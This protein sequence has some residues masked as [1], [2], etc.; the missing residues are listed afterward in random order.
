MTGQSEPKM[1]I[2]VAT[3]SDILTLAEIHFQALPNDLLPRIGKKFL[4]EY[5]YPQLLQSKHAL[6]LVYTQGGATKSFVVF[7][8]DSD[9]LTQYILSQ[10]TKM[11]L[12]LIPATF[13]SYKLIFDV[14][15]H[16]RGSELKLNGKSDLEIGKIPE[17]Y[18]MATNS[19][20]T[21]SGV[22]GRLITEGL[23]IMAN[24]SPSCMV[25]TSS[26]RAK[27]FYMKY[28]FKEIGFERRGNRILNLLLR[29]QKTK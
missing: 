1:A 23:K 22:G 11:A 8:Y 26:E 25:K 4:Q 21:S 27:K 28:G 17:L 2:R 3:E 19:K 5:F 24:T 16:L 9:A 6:T 15:S 20:Y 12:Y 7:A 13:R 14:F 18:L 10:R 29:T